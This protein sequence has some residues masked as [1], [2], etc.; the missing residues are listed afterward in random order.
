[1]TPDRE[2]LSDLPLKMRS[3]DDF[4]SVVEVEET[5]ATYAANAELKAAG[6]ARQTQLWALAEDSGL[7]VTALNGAPGVFSARYMGA[8]GT[9]QQR[10]ERVL[11]ELHATPTAERCA[12]FICVMALAAPTGDIILSETGLCG[13]HISSGP[14]GTNGFGYDSIFVPD[15]FEKTFGELP[16]LLKQKISHRAQASKR[17]VRHL[18][19][20]LAS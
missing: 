9:K 20:F 19:E 2:L 16:A 10:N 15:G 18:N 13:G 12:Q 7:E 4:A 5:G 3:L 6:Y 11:S 1:L 17:I 14:R 8:A